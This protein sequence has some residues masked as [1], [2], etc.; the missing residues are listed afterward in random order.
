V[1]GWGLRVATAPAARSAHLLHSGCEVLVLYQIPVF[2]KS[3]VLR[4]WYRMNA[5][6]A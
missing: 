3:S 1:S 6:G 5:V 4:K 2:A